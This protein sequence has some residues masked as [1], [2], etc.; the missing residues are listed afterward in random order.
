MT[1]QA[2][3]VLLVSL[4]DT[5]RIEELIRIG[6]DQ[7]AIPTPLLRPVTAWAVERYFRSG[8]KTAPTRAAL[9][10]TW[11]KQLANEGIELPSEDEDTDPTEWAVDT[12]KSNY[13][14]FKY[15]EFQKASAI[16]V[17]E[18]DTPDR[19]RVLSEQANE[20]FTLSTRMQPKHM[21]MDGHLGFQAALSSYRIREEEGHQVRGM[22]F[23]LD[24]VDR[25]TY[26]IHPG[27][28]AIIAAGPKTGKSFFLDRVALHEARQGR[29][30]VLYTLE[31]SVEMTY[32]R[33]VC[34]ACHV[35]ARAWARGTCEPEEVERV[36]AFLA[37]E[38]PALKEHLQVI[39]PGE[40]ERT[41]G[42]MVRQAQMFGADSI[43]VDQLTFVEPP[44]PRK[45]RHEQLRDIMHEA[46][47]L[48]TTGAKPMP[49]LLAHQINREGV[50]L[51]AKS[52]FL[53]MHML[54]E[55]SEVERT[56]DW[57]FGLYQS[58]QERKLL[59][60]TLQVLAARREDLNAW[61][62]SWAVQQGFIGVIGEKT[63]EE[64]A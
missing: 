36:E 3:D 10:E 40:A 45:A 46:K 53:E 39:T 12:L 61:Q 21:Q 41:M 30:T 56:A 43:L 19:V 6:L 28:L 34:L 13:V 37:D 54:A 60:S 55:G 44:D 9:L 47:L 8:M 29:R 33:I 5:D 57:V 16:A 38:A 7:E 1:S 22:T 24:M 15:Q 50:K 11:G 32:N 59:Q 51:A 49:M 20:L 62:L 63:L 25:H 31:N 48:L 4:T 26:G 35:D 52:G 64:Q 18:A 14:H 27:E 2:E 23:G 58:P 17:A 42:A